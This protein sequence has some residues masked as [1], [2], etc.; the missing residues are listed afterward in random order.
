MTWFFGLVAIAWALLIG[1]GASALQAPD[2][3]GL[4]S[5]APKFADYRFAPRVDPL[6]TNLAVTEIWAR[7]WYPS[8]KTSRSPLVVLLHGNHSTCGR[9]VG[10]F[11]IDDRADYSSTGQC[12]AGYVVTPN[13]VGYDYVARQLASR[14]YI[15]VSI[16]VNRGINAFG[17]DPR[18]NDPGLILR[19][20]RMILRHMQLLSQWSRSGGQ[21]GSIPYN[22]RNRIDFSRVTLFG[23]SRGGDGI[24]AAY[25]L[26]KTQAA[27]RQRVPGVTFVGIAS[28]A[29]TD[30]QSAR[31][32]VIG[33]PLSVLLPMCDGDVNRLS[34]IGFYDR[35]VRGDLPDTLHNFKSVLAVWGANHN[36]Y[37]TQWQTDDDNP[38]DHTCPNQNRLFQPGPGLVPQQQT[39]GL[40]YLMAVA[41]GG[42]ETANFARL[43]NP[44]YALPPRMR[45]I[46]RYDRSYFAG[47]G[48]R[49]L[50]LV[51]FD[52]ICSQKFAVSNGVFGQCSN[53]PEHN[54]PTPAAVVR[55]NAS[56]P[57]PFAVFTLNNGNPV[58]LDAFTTVDIRVGPDCHK[59]SRQNGDFFCDTPTQFGNGTGGAQDVTVLF[60]DSNGVFSNAVNLVP[61]VD[62]REAVGIS[63]V[64]LPVTPL[65]H[66][67]LSSARIPVSRFLNPGFAADSVRKIYVDLGASHNTGGLFFGDI[68][69]VSVGNT[70]LTDE[71]AEVADKAAP[72]AS[73]AVPSDLR[74]TPVSDVRGADGSASSSA[75][76]VP[77]PAEPGNRIL[78]VTRGVLPVPAGD[79]AA[80]SNPEL[81]PMRSVPSVSFTVA[82]DTQ[83][84]EGDAGMALRFGD[85]QVA[86]RR[87][88]TGRENETPSIIRLVVP[89]DALARVPDGA[90]LAVVSAGSVRRFGPFSKASIR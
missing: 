22:L 57:S 56:A 62:K 14:G 49:S 16:N 37:N 77:P 70:A 83:I 33:A 2:P 42:S 13:H 46:T 4:G 45:S 78:A 80:D 87:F 24:V 36:G 63:T 69:A 32:N 47:R 21:P 29:P 74:L 31:P 68:Y 67:L 60:S 50:R 35:S 72:V 19:R 41:R 88:A 20:G 27:W 38:N 44:A 12:P 15:A 90:G 85:Y 6:V 81:V 28:M 52:G 55:W 65:Y 11:R 79:S 9:R 76:S 71:P 58:N 26:Y 84:V 3:T 66:A 75:R 10:Q 1:S 39:I 51:R 89:A 86:A 17:D 5:F 59:V 40:Y 53:L 25:N 18:E 34:G 30:F 7:L 48:P 43:L 23:H 61:F 54:S 82:T 64:N 8:N 73:A